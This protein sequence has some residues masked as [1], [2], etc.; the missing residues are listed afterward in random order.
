MVSRSDP[1]PSAPTGTR[2]SGLIFRGGL[3]H[4]LGYKRRSTAPGLLRPGERTPAPVQTRRP[5]STYLSPDDALARIID[6][7]DLIERLVRTL[8]VR[9]KAERG[10]GQIRIAAGRIKD[11]ARVLSGEDS[12]RG[13][14]RGQRERVEGGDRLAGGRRR[15][16]AAERLSAVRPG[17]RNGPVCGAFRRGV[18]GL[19][20]LTPSVS[21]WCAECL[22]PLRLGIRQLH[23]RPPSGWIPLDND[24]QTWDEGVLAAEA[25]AARRP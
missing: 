11:Y 19:E 24:P 6:E 21:S 17:T 2:M 15:G 4:G 1:G 7:A 10:Q 22:R 8:E 5:F 9:A 25:G 14:A 20:P 23:H 16:R 12:S 3:G 18:T 13:G